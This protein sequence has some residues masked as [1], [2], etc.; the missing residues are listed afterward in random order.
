MN[1]MCHD[2]AS[3][4]LKTARGWKRRADSPMRLAK[5]VIGPYKK[6]VVLPAAGQGVPAVIAP[7]VT[8]MTVTS[9]DV[10]S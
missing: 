4:H 1:A 7:E 8:R 3:S 6:P 2:G 10:A 5:G 9:P